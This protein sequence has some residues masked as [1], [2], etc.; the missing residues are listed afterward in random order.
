MLKNPLIIFGCVCFPGIFGA[1]IR[2]LQNTT[3]FE[4]GTGLAVPNSLW[5]IVM[6]VYLVGCAVFVFFVSRVPK[7]SSPRNMQDAFENALPGV[8]VAGIVGPLLIAAGGLMELANALKTDSG[9]S[10]L[11]GFF[12]MAVGV[13]LLMM[14]RGLAYGKPGVARPALI[15]TVLWLC[16]LMVWE[17][18]TCAADPVI[19]HFAIK[20]LAA[21]ATLLAWYYIAGFDFGRMAPGK[22]VYFSML[23]T[24]LIFIRFADG[25]GMGINLVLGGM[26]LCQMILTVSLSQYYKKA[27]S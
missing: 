5:S 17:Y 2:W 4:T 27:K 26:A 12:A 18:K 20:V 8:N 21:A 24:V 22:M 16:L 19:W 7:A 9:F 15:I 14:F 11:L 13:S 1:F 10:L 3:A 6:A 25:D 23:S